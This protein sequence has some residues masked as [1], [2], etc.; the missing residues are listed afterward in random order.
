MSVDVQVSVGRRLTDFVVGDA[1]VHRLDKVVTLLTVQNVGVGGSRNLDRDIIRANS[2]DG[3]TSSGGV[4]KH[5]GASSQGTRSTEID[6]VGTVAITGKQDRL[7]NLR[8][9]R[10]SYD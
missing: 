8:P 2:P 6:L 5:P 4:D 10:V 9:A 7:V 3:L 1:R